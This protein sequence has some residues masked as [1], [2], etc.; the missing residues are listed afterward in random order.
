MNR[1]TLSNITVRKRLIFF[2]ICIAALVFAFI[3][4]LGWL[5][6]VHGQELREKAW[7]QWTRINV[8]RAQRGNIYDRN[9]ELLAGSSAS[10]SI[11]ARPGQIDDKEKTAKE[12]ASILEM[13]ENRLLELLGK[14]IDSV[15]L[16]RQM[17]ED[18][19]QEIRKLNLEGVYFTPEP[20]RIY[21]HG[22]LAS[23]LLGFVGT[24]EGLAGLEYQYEEELKGQDGRIELQ[25][26]AKG[27]RLP[28]G[29]EV[30]F[31]PERGAD[32][33]LTIDQKIQF[34]LEREMDRV[35]LESQ[36]KSIVALAMAP[37]TGEI[38]GIA[39]KPDFDPNDYASYPQEN[40]KLTP[41]SN[42]FEPGS[43]YKLV[44][45][46][47][48]LE[49]GH[50]NANEGFFCRGYA[51][52]AGTTI[53]CWTRD[54]GG[55]GAIDFTQVVLGSC[56]PGFIELGERIGPDKLMEY[57]QA[58]GFG[59]KTGVDIAGESTGIL[60]TPEQFG[61]VEAATT[62][63]GQGVSCTPLQQ[64][65]AVSAM[66][67][68][69]YLMKPYIVK[70]L[71]DSEGNITEYGPQL[72][73]QVVSAETSAEI[74]RIM[75][76]VVTEGSGK[77]AY[78]EGYRMGGKTG[79]AQKVGEGG[80]YIDGEHILSFI[81]FAPAEDPKILLYIA[82]DTPQVGPQWGSQ[83]SAPM[84]RRM[85]ESILQYL[86]IPPSTVAEETVPTIVEVPDLTGLSLDDHTYNLLETRGL[87]I[88][89]IGSGETILN[90]TPKAGARVPLH[91]EVLVYLGG[92]GEEG[93]DKGVTVPDLQ[94]KSMREAGEI[95]NWLGLRINSTGTGVVV[96]QDPEA[97]TQVPAGSVVD[98]E[99]AVP[100]DE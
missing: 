57:V 9:G 53:G 83:V 26:D 15:Y 11:L 58:F 34:I 22:R 20:K 69:G 45:L 91:T 77:N 52:V 7:E 100:G 68:S 70:G 41:I 48:A 39:G 24:D 64:A 56:N 85:M 10:L 79:T 31:P 75:E 76:L 63:F 19:A 23:Q 28:Q 8:A 44:T 62:A 82:V 21:P 96:R 40:W 35:M 17:D 16:K 30:F 80:R 98:V 66:I 88:R 67:N 42:T 74:R 87:L 47:A 55:H 78:I 99:F 6:L 92:S 89:F 51:K 3:C 38:L 84:F 5:Q 2:F 25:T 73:R 33:I 37:H 13:D 81:G 86:N 54:R 29:R 1:Q 61:P 65:V 18:V 94:G 59:E 93:E 4:R 43:T 50:Y 72:I 27:K 46:S 12:L 71:R 49:E 60:F 14:E 97:G 90:Q 32:L 36:P 95:L